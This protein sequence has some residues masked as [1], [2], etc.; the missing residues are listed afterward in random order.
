MAMKYSPLF[1]RYVLITV[2]L[3]SG[4]SCEEEK[5]GP[6]RTIDFSAAPTQ[7][8]IPLQVVFN[9]GSNFDSEQWHWDFGDGNTSTLQYPIYVY[10]KAGKYDVSLT[11][12]SDSDT[13]IMTKDDFIVAIRPNRPLAHFSI[14][15][16][17]TPVDSRGFARDT[18]YFLKDES[19]GVITK[20]EWDLGDGRKLSERNPSFVFSSAGEYTIKLTVTGEGGTDT[21]SQTVLVDEIFEIWAGPFGP[22]WPEREAG[23]CDFGGNAPKITVAASMLAPWEIT[24]PQF[25]NGMSFMVW[26]EAEEQGGDRSRATGRWQVSVVDLDENLQVRSWEG[27]HKMEN[28][29]TY[30]DNNFNVDYPPFMRGSDFCK[31]AVMGNTS[32][33]DI[34]NKTSNDTH[35]IIEEVHVK[36]RIGPKS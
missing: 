23:D 25:D 14:R 12:I 29:W 9:N 20:W 16:D 17:P 26:M 6:N 3:I 7:G 11:A 27:D 32:G 4:L 19:V 15:L 36:V 1:L 21:Y 35:V 10:E 34:C 30:T 33:S 13:L 22:F 24:S 28:S 8:L 31:M 2:I 5:K 18:K